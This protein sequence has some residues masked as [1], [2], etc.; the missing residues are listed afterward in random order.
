[1]GRRPLIIAC[2]ALLA[3]ANGG[4]ISADSIPMPK[5]G[6]FSAMFWEWMWLNVT[7][8]LFNL[9]IPCYPLDGSRILMAFL[10]HGQKYDNKTCQ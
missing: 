1:M 4:D 2:L 8:M 9:C 7:L 5:D 3:L 6:F 10:Q